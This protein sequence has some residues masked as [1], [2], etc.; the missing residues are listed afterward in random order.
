MAG[1]LA[2]AGVAAPLSTRNAELARIHIGAAELGWRSANDDD[3]YR[4]QLYAVCRVSSAKD[5]D[6][7]GRRRFL[8]HMAACG[9]RF[10]GQGKRRRG[11]QPGGRV[12]PAQLDLLKHLWGCLHRAG[13]VRHGDD[14]ALRRWVVGQTKGRVDAPAF[15]D[16]ATAG[17]LIERLKGWC[18]RLGVDRHDG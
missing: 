13:Q 7:A 17:T 12:S 1:G 16:A 6:Q 9:C 8:D 14:Q 3:E 5:L 2:G 18:D 11:R 15:L 10:R 4:R